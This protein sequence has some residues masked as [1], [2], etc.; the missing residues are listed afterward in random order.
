MKTTTLLPLNKAYP[1]KCYK[2]VDIRLNNNH[3]RRILDL[4]LIPKT[5]LKVLQKSPLGD[6]VAYLIR[7]SVIALREEYTKK[8]IV[9]ELE[10]N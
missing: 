1:G 5:T 4:G 6:P 2:V 10:T 9:K 8:V 7:G 3:R